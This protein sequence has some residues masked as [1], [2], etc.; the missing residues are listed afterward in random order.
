MLNAEECRTHAR[1]CVK[2]AKEPNA[3]KQ[4]A[5]VLLAMSKSWAGLAGQMDR[6]DAILKSEREQTASVEGRR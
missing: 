1:D 6:Y 2:L 3:P 4:R 5:G